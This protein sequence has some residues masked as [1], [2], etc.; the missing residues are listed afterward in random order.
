[1]DTLE[2]IGIIIEPLAEDSETDLSRFYQHAQRVCS[3]DK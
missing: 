1:M 3:T 2:T